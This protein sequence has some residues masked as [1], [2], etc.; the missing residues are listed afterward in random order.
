MQALGKE[1]K[2]WAMVPPGRV[3]EQE[4]RDLPT[5]ETKRGSCSVAGQGGPRRRCH[6]WPSWAAHE[7]CWWAEQGEAG[8]TRYR[9]VLPFFLF[10]LFSFLF[11][12]YQFKFKFYC[13]VHI[14][15]RYTYSSFQYE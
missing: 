10:L 6:A 15:T 2:Q 1:D 3:C 4:L 12:G 11:L 5:S 8:P 7:G 13:G 14:W 9:C